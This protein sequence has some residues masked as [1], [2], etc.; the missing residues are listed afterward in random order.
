[1]MGKL[2][3]LVAI[4]AVCFAENIAAITI[5]GYYPGPAFFPA[6][7]IRGSDACGLNWDKGKIITAELPYKNEDYTNTK[8]HDTHF[9]STYINKYFPNDFELS[10]EVT[11]NLY[12]QM[13]EIMGAVSSIIKGN[14]F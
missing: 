4:V 2:C 1:M 11:D 10:K 5:V 7:Y 9:K 3:C 13:N 6:L 14:A 12:E 8:I